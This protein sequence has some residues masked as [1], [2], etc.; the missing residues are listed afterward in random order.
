MNQCLKIPRLELTTLK[1]GEDGY[2]IGVD[3]YRVGFDGSKIR[4]GR[5][6][7]WVDGSMVE[8]DRLKKGNKE[9]MAIVRFRNIYILL[10]LNHLTNLGDTYG[11]F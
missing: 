6:K 11:K 4:V 5:S 10:T 8:D 3:D 7:F 1:I 9:K 2:R